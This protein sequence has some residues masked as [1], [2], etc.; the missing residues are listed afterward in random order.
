MRKVT[1]LWFAHLRDQR[2]CEREV[3]ETAMTTLD[4]LYDE[5]AARHHISLPRKSVWPAVGDDLA[6]WDAPVPADGVVAFLPPV[7]GG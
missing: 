2:G 7:S 3:V 1:I 6:R 5:L 4:A